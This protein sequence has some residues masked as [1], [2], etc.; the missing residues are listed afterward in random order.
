[1]KHIRL[2]CACSCIK[3][4]LQRCY[5]FR[6][7][8]SQSKSSKHHSTN[9]NHLNTIQPIKIMQ[10]SF[11]R[12]D[13]CKS[14]HLLK[15]TV[16][17]KFTDFGVQIV[18]CTKKTDI[19]IPKE[20]WESLVECQDTVTSHVNGR[21]EASW[22]LAEDIRIS[23]SLFHNHMY[24]HIRHWFQKHPTR[25]GLSLHESQWPELCTHLK[26]TDEMRLA[27][28]VM[29]NMMKTEVRKMMKKQC[30]GCVKGYPSQTDHECLMNPSACA[31]GAIDSINI[32]P[33]DFILKLAQEGVKDSVILEKPHDVYKRVKS[34]HMNTIRQSIIDEY[35]CFM[36]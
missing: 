25:K 11:I 19:T 9:Q 26:D 18:N 24:I 10:Y 34:F 27:K 5:G 36:E 35:D 15:M 28:K 6:I 1:M 3:H 32:Q 23:T 12:E 29:L 4:M 20:A 8:Y 30:E 14:Y 31:S 7:C 17:V 22:P 13:I 16:E 2:T 21:K 33:H